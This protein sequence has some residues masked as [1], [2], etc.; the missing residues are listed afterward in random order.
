MRIAIVRRDCRMKALPAKAQHC[1]MESWT[2]LKARRMTS[3]LFVVDLA[4]DPCS[5]G[6]FAAA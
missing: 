6:D 4:K 3:E 2:S 1:S 5:I